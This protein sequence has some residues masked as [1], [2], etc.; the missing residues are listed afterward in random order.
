MYS[1]NETTTDL[2]GFEDQVEDLCAIVLN[3]ALLPVTVGVLGDWGSGKSSLLLMAEQR[4][5]AAGSVVVYFSPW[6]IEDYDDAKSA[7]L[8][9]VV[10]AV[11]AHL[12]SSEMT[13]EV[14][15]KIVSKL[16]ALR[17]RVKWLRAAGMAAKHLVTMTAPSLDELDGLLRSDSEDDEDAPST[18]RLTRDFH[19]EFKAVVSD[20]GTNVIVLVDDL[21]RCQPEQV[22]DVLHATRLF[23]SVPG[24]AFVLATDERVVRDAV[25]IRYPQATDASETDLP[26][27]YLE[28][29]VQF[30]IRLPTLGNADV[31]SFLNLLVAEDHFEGDDL[32]TLRAR[33]ST[34]RSEGLSRVAMNVGIAR[35]LVDVPPDAEHAFDLVARIAAV[36]GAGLKG[37]PR[38]LKRFLNGLSLRRA[39]AERRGVMDELSE[40]VMAKLA[41]LEYVGHRRF[42]EL[43]EAQLASN[44]QPHALLALERKIRGLPVDGAHGARAEDA[45]D[46]ED[47][48]AA[49]ADESVPVDLG[50][51][52]NWD[53]SDL[54]R[55][56]LRMEPSLEGVDLAPYFLLARDSVHDNSLQARRLP[57]DLQL[58]LD[59]LG[60][61][62]QGQRDVAVNSALELDE[63][64]LVQ[65]VDAGIERMSEGLPGAVELGLSLA[66]L[67]EPRPAM[68][69]PVLRA[70]ATLPY[71][72][73]SI[74]LPTQLVSRLGSVAKNDLEQLL[75]A[76]MGQ[77]ASGRL[78]KAAQSARMVLDGHQ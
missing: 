18:A 26:Q 61:S 34:L 42:Q 36:L 47:D 40:Q 24:T 78:S 56:W 15:T 5:R 37:N 41:V 38:Q 73:I 46:V 43:H 35:D 50:A 4:L 48:A 62:S 9:A 65:L 21:D 54:M 59:G 52:A 20:L 29:I 25:R 1:D 6:R 14:R 11:D 53:S 8:D 16:G 10:H 39:L 31:E 17:R 22:L 58:L 63:A 66:S 67:C 30:P 23:L 74:A 51:L 77:G 72:Q 44:G 32:E 75:N 68:C 70:F 27:E 60:S 57:S 28:K 71:T 7:L 12:A 3:E 76:W 69:G 33:A 49:P 64:R 55:G 2:L 45:D 13:D 19:E